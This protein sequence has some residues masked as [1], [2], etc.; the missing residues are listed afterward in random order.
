MRVMFWPEMIVIKPGGDYVGPLMERVS[1]Q[2]KRIFF[3]NALSTGDK[4]EHRHSFTISQTDINAAADGGQI[5]LPTIV[6]HLEYEFAF[7]P[8]RRI[9][10]F[11]LFSAGQIDVG[12]EE[13][14]EIAMNWI[15]GTSPIRPT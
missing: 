11:V 2:K 15:I 10:P 14:T 5:V 12:S 8:T 9:T 6:G 13:G 7:D 1:R 3:E 4:I